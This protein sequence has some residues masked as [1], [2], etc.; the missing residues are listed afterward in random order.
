MS[1]GSSSTS[2][3][4]GTDFFQRTKSSFKNR[5][6]T[7]L[8]G[9]GAL[10]TRLREIGVD[11]SEAQLRALQQTEGFQTL[12]SGIAS[13]MLSPRALAD[14]EKRA[15]EAGKLTDEEARLIDQAA[16][17]G[18]ARG[19]ADI[20]Q[21]T[22]EGLQ[23]LRE[24]LAPSR[25]LRGSDS[26]IFERGGDIVA[27]GVRQKGQLGLGLQQQAA[28]QRLQFP[29]ERQAFQENLRNA[30]FQN[31]LALSGQT[32]QGGLGL[33][34]LFNPAGFSNQFLQERIAGRDTL[35]RGHGDSNTI[36]SSRSQSHSSTTEGSFD[37]SS[38]AGGF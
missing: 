35:R 33:S 11:I 28:G 2:S 9:A 13:D 29:L 21:A 12:L 24:E 16:S 3:G 14:A 5:D 22:T 20:D 23:L 25:G 38:L 31:R 34:G 10:E 37:F 4:S 27:E 36:G 32:V 30:A 19:A 6:I 8:E 26:P 18:F 17:L 1:I 7:E 15:G